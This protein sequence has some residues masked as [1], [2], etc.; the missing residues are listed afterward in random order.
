M[1]NYFV[2]HNSPAFGGHL[3]ISLFLFTNVENYHS[4]NYNL[5]DYFEVFA[6]G[7]FSSNVFTVLSLMTTNLDNVFCLHMSIYLV[8]SGSVLENDF[9]TPPPL[10]FFFAHLNYFFAHLNYF[11]LLI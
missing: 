9:W 6:R 11:F 3:G 4:F 2:W 7:L 10:N 1:S 5:F 8:I